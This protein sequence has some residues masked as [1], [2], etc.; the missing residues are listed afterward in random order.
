MHTCT[1]THMH[2]CTHAHIHTCA[3]AHM[4]TYTH[5]H[6]HICTHTHMHTVWGLGSLNAHPMCLFAGSETHFRVVVVSDD[7]E[8]LPLIKVMFM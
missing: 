7:F 6:M 8:G 5:A 3:H 1:H 2:T 4:H